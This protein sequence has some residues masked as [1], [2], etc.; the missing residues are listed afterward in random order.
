MARKELTDA[1]IE[2]LEQA[3]SEGLSDYEIEQMESLNEQFPEWQS[4]LVGAQDMFLAGY[5]PNALAAIKTGSISSPEYIAERD[6]LN[7]T[8]E[9]MKQED[10][11]SFLAGQFAGGAA[12]M[13]IPGLTAAKGARLGARMAR[14]ALVGGATGALSDTPDVEGQ[15]TSPLSA[16]DIKERATLAAQGAVL[17]PVAELGATAIRAVTPDEINRAFT[18]LQ[19]TKGARKEARLATEK[20]G[21]AAKENLMK[22]AKEE[23]ITEGIPSIEDLYQRSLDSKTKYGESLETIY[24]RAQEVVDEQMHQGI[25]PAKIRYQKNLNSIPEIKDKVLKEIEKKD[26]ADADKKRAVGQISRYFDNLPEDVKRLPDLLQLHEIKTAIGSKGFKEGKAMSASSTDEFW[27]TAGRFVDDE[28]KKRVDGLS[29]I[30][31]KS[32]DKQLGEALRE[33]NRRYSLSSNIYNMASNAVDSADG[34]RT[35]GLFDMFGDLARRPEVQMG[36]SKAGALESK[37][38]QALQPSGAQVTVPLVQSLQEATRLPTPYEIQEQIRQDDR[39]TPGQK[40]RAIYELY[41]RTK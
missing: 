27:R 39:M 15:V 36:L 24:K 33:A 11:G 20:G 1:E 25:S 21:L 3:D 37:I 13:A 19:P 8:V 17:G 26:W 22:F 35:T 16:E 6:K 4:G 2:A 32:R 23:G 38:P 31:G 40:G 12:S 34:Q 5:G 30:A 41:K 7:A 28:I 14:A 29:E 9:A 10:P 18:A